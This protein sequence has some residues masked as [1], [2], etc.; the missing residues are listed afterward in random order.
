MK[1]PTLTLDLEAVR[2]NVRVWRERLRGTEIWA[3]VKSD[4]YRLG[5]V[6]VARASLEAGAT[7][8]CVVDVDEAGA[9]RRAGIDA[10]IVLIWTTPI[11]D[12]DRALALGAVVTIEDVEGARALSRRAEALGVEAVAHVAVETGTGW[13]GVPAAQSRGFADAV[14][15]VAAV[16]WEGAWTHIAGRDS[17]PAQLAAFHDAVATMR[18]AGLGLPITHYASTGPAIWQPGGAAARIGVGLYGS[19]LGDAEVGRSLR[20]ALSLRAQIA[21]LRT[22]TTDTPLGYGGT[23]VASAGQ[24]IA[25]V[26]A[27][28]VD[29]LSPAFFGSVICGGRRCPVVGAIG[30]NFTMIVYPQAL[31]PA[32]D[33]EVLFLTDADGVRIDDFTRASRSTSHAAIAALGCAPL[34]DGSR[35]S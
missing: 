35:Q 25:T 24:C 12:F 19:A 4:A 18:A 27:G 7:R 34:Q 15:D 23:Y 33:E 11:S 21:C 32:S 2:H 16:C 3:C 13:S 30:M 28:Y 20:T 8:L 1:G 26:R 22:F 14:R 5:A 9:L 6:R 31:V 17:C 29:G 10:P